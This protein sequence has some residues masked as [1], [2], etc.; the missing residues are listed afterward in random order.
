MTDAGGERSRYADAH[1]TLIIS[2]ETAS[3]RGPD[4]YTRQCDR[5]KLAAS[6]AG[7]LDTSARD[8]GSFRLSYFAKRTSAYSIVLVEALIE[9]GSQLRCLSGN[10]S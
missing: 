2:A 6:G 3:E 7:R 5:A 9:V 10:W 8:T 1:S 4:T